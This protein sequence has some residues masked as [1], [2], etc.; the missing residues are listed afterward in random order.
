M[1]KKYLYVIV[2]LLQWHK[3]KLYAVIV[4]LLFLCCTKCFGQVTYTWN[5]TGVADWTIDV[6]WTPAR[7]TPAANDILL[8]NNGSV[9]T[10]TN[11]PLQSVGQLSVS[12]NTTINLQAATANNVLT[13]EGITGGD[14]LIVTAGSSF[15]INGTNPATVFLATG[16]TASIGGSINFSVAAHRLD[17]ADA[18]SIVFNSPA[19]FTQDAGCS[20]NVF[21]A[22]GTANAI[23]FNTGTTFIQK[24]G[25]NPF[26][27]TQPASKVVFNTGSLFKVQQILF[28]SFSGR[29]YANLEIDFPAFNQS[30]TGVNPLNI[31]N[32]LITQGTLSLNLTGG[33]NIKGNT[34]VSAGQ[35]LN[36]NP[37]SAGTVSFNGAILQTIS[38]SGTITFNSNEAINFSN[39]AG[40][41]INSNISFN[42]IVN[43]ISGIVT[44]TDPAVLTLSATASVAGVSNNSFVDGLV[45]KVG[46][47]AF[48][49]PVGKTGIGYVPLS[50][51]APGSITDE[52]TAAYKRESAQAL[53]NNYAAGLDHVSGVDY[54]LLNRGSGTTAIDVTLYWTSQSSANGSALYI[55]D[56]SK[57]VMAHYNG[58]NQWNTYGGTFN[59]GSGFAAGSIT[60]AGVNTFSPF[61][62]ASTDASNP[63]PVKLDYFN[64]YTQDRKNYFNWKVTSTIN[65][66]TK[67]EVQRSKE[68]RNFSTAFSITA[69]A[70][71]CLQAFDYVD[72]NPLS[73]TDYYRLKIIDAN[74][75]VIYSSIIVLQN[76]S[77]D[78]NISGLMPSIVRDNAILNITADK[79]TKINMVI[80]DVAGRRVL[81]LTSDLAAGNNHLPLNLVQLSPGNYQ[82]TGYAMGVPIKTIRFV[83]Q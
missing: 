6:N 18:N 50:I 3:K 66:N 33:I 60:W 23:V 5:K 73:G 65:A 21:T 19:V 10:A 68:G 40:V 25:A 58:S 17:A 36:F 53:S 24:A 13:I 67:I 37:A 39:A 15:N 57:L 63:L 45:K 26:A 49:F 44:V 72:A 22:A 64:G 31:N 82:L 47:T 2:L 79:K 34:S 32:L 29:T 75:T 8:F 28:L 14:D 81:Q 80:T 54:W 55:N 59:A 9:N 52:Y 1:Q 43:F 77:Y 71:R 74:G 46:N 70:L 4:F 62:L 83:K 38:N 12:N 61:S 78:F 20:G 16:A 7:T 41:K 48:I 42:S 35:V 30:V 76:N 69:D 51:S 56:L 11:V 27:L